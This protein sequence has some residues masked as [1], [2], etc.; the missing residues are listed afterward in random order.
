MKRLGITVRIGAA[1]DSVTT[2]D[3]MTLDR[4]RMTKADKR[5]LS[6]LV[7]DIYSKFTKRD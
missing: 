2:S 7:R 4:S 3:G 5:K 1:H 6:R